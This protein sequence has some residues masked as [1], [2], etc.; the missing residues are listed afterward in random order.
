MLSSEFRNR[1]IAPYYNTTS[2]VIEL[3]DKDGTILFNNT[4]FAPQ[5]WSYTA[6]MIAASKYSRDEDQTREGIHVSKIFRRV[7][8]FLKHNNKLYDLNDEFFDDLF[9]L[10]LSQT[11]AFNSPVYFNATWNAIKPYLSACFIGEILD[12]MEDIC[13]FFSLEG[14]IF[15]GGGGIGVN[16]SNLRGS[17]ELLSNSR[18]TSS[19]PLS[20]GKAFD[21]FSGV[22]KSGGRTRRAAKLF[23]MDDDHP[24]IMNF[25]NVKGIEEQKAKDLCA[26]GWGDP[27]DINSEAIRTVAFQN[28]NNS[29]RLT[30]K[31]MKWHDKDWLLAHRISD[32]QETVNYNDMWDAIL[33]NIWKSGCP[34]VHFVDNI[35]QWNPFKHNKIQA[36]NPCSEVTWYNNSAC[37]LASINLAKFIYKD[38]DHFC[39]DINSFMTV[40]QIFIT[41]MDIIVDAAGYPSEKIKKNSKF[42]RPL[43]L[44]L[45]NVAG[46]LMRLC[47]PYESELACKI[48]A[49]ITMLMTMTAYHASMCLQ[50]EAK[51]KLPEQEEFNHFQI[52]NNI[53]KHK[54]TF[55]KYT[56]SIPECFQLA[57]LSDIIDTVNSTYTEIIQNKNNRGFRNAQVTVMAPAGTIS[58]IMDCDSTGLEPLMS[59]KS[60]KKLSGGGSIV[61]EPPA[62]QAALNLVNP[63]EYNTSQ[64][65]IFAT[66]YDEDNMISPEGHINMCAAVQPFISGGISKTIALPTNYSKEKI[67]ELIYM[68]WEKGIKCVSFYRNGSKTAQPLQFKK[69]E[70]KQQATYELPKLTRKRLSP[71]RD[72]KCF[73]VNIGGS[74]EYIKLGFYPDGRVG[75]IWIDMAKEGSL[76]SGLLDALARSISVALQYGV[77]IQEFIEG[78]VGFTFPPNGY[79]TDPKIPFAKSVIDYLARLISIRYPNGYP[80]TTEPPAEPPEPIPSIEKNHTA[81]GIPCPQCGDMIPPNKCSCPWC[82]YSNG[83][84]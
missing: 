46:F 18:G 45:T 61:I 49:S 67:K 56:K 19:G 80:A 1:I 28:V 14:K 31:F 40:V 21:A 68:S 23:C 22:I 70:E 5:A 27:G 44:G 60:I 41:C 37:N 34:G 52:I 6:K 83:C 35:E 76:T 77:P 10:Q 42:Y 9:D 8:N 66:A 58:L 63:K 59:K 43:G 12:N 3:K 39:F 15:K 84:A 82:G 65:K 79:T 57:N 73:E 47:I 16:L 32:K 2:E 24:D 11:V 81:D 64:S 74:K 29:V 33:E 13:D 20:F 53:A 36:T 54:T 72:L 38:K 75:E 62:I 7:C 78:F 4:V 17:M 25:I 50:Q 51:S 30:D 48:I 55:E 69:K 26:A 71:E